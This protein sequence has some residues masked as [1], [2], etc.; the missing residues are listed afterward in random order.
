[1]PRR[2]PFP[3]LAITGDTDVHQNILAVA[4]HGGLSVSGW[5]TMAAREA[6][7][8]AGR[9]GGS[10]PVGEAT[11]QIHCGR[12]GRSAPPYSHADAA[13][14][15]RSFDYNSAVRGAAES[16]RAPGVF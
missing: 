15:M 4:A 14:S 8:A 10:R 2:N 5:I 1:M 13:V 9:I 3:R 6:A 7:V 11:P 16:K 12:N